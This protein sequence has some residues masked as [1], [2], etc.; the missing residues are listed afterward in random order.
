MLC[1]NAFTARAHFY[2][3]ALP[4]CYG[5]LMLL[6]PIGSPSK[7]QAFRCQPLPVLGFDDDDGLYLYD[8]L[9]LQLPVELIY[10]IVELAVLSNRRTG[11]SLCLVSSWVREVTLPLMYN[12]IVLQ[13]NMVSPFNIPRFIKNAPRQLTS[14][15]RHIQRLWI[16][17][18]AEKAPRTLDTCPHLEQLAMHLE[19]HEAI[20]Q[21]RFWAQCIDGHAV[22][23]CRSFT[24]LGQSH[25]SRWVPFT[26]S[27]S[28]L[29]FLRG[30]THLRL[31]NMCLS[32]YIPLE[33]TPNLTHLCLPYFDLRAATTEGTEFSGLEYIL[34]MPHL[35]MVV[36]TLNPRYWRFDEMS[37]KAWAIHAMAK[38]ERLYVVASTRLDATRDW[39]DP[40]R[41]WENEAL[42]GIS[43]W[44]KAVQVRNKFIARLSRNGWD[45][46]RYHL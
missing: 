30:L 16:D 18:G 27:A 21:T 9:D 43:I 29:A 46:D 25:P 4:S 10:Y 3:D 6:S 44:D 40:R 22:T 1:G 14:P 23:P 38:D 32:H 37:L 31:L 45:V 42:G 15:M 34:S 24:V 35:Q 5:T 26:Q 28:G 19:M 39:E 41:D 11:L 33:Y 7:L 20:T 13:G 8:D 36:L 12:T 17:V 2:L